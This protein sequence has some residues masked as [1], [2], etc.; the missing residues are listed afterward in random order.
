MRVDAA[1]I[2]ST[3]ELGEFAT[4]QRAT[5][6]SAQDDQIAVR[7]IPMPERQTI[8]R[9]MIY[10]AT[11]TVMATT[12]DLFTINRRDLTERY[13]E[14]SWAYRVLFA[15]PPSTGLQRH[16]CHERLTDVF[17]VIDRAR[18]KS[19]RGADGFIPETSETTYRGKLVLSD[20][21]HVT[22]NRQRRMRSDFDLYLEELPPLNTDSLIVDS[23]G[24]A[25]R[26]GQVEQS[27]DREDLPYMTLSRIDS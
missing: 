8:R 12:G 5:E 9:A 25:Y 4:F 6:T 17:S 18:Y 27:I 2:L 13:S 15:D 19:E 20:A 26:I 3:D 24:R 21:E 14:T 1:A 22:Q 11:Q 10:T 16:L 23:S 7:F